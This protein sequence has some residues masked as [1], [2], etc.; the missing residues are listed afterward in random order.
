MSVALVAQGEKI[1]T[2]AVRSF[3]NAWLFFLFRI[4]V[5]VEIRDVTCES[6]K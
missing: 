2:R 4:P 3:S 1:S 6:Y 5:D